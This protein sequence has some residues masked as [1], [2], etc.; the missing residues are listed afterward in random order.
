MHFKEPGSTGLYTWTILTGQGL[1][2][3][4]K[5]FKYF[6]KGIPTARP[7]GSETMAKIYII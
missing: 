5:D 6:F 4:E 7:L 2:L 3:G 1:G